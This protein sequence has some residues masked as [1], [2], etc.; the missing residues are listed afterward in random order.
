MTESESEITYL[1]DTNVILRYLL[2]DHPDFSPKSIRFMADV[3]K[4]KV[5]AEIQDIVLL[6]CIFV[7]EKHYKVPRKLIVDCL[8]KII[9]FEGI[10]NTNKAILINAL[11]IY[12]KHKTDIGDCL[13]CSYSSENRIVVSFGRDFKMLNAHWKNL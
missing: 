4:G 13:L 10:I 3:S 5:K 11:F 9:N 1:I 12:E 8:G 2:H 6:E 7:M